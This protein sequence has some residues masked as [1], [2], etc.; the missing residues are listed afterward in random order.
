MITLP[1]NPEITRCLA[2]GQR[3]REWCDRAD[4]CARHLTIH[5]DPMPP[6]GEISPNAV[7]R[8]CSSDLMAGYLPMEGF[9]EA[10]A[11]E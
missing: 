11:D 9:P 8:A 5:C 4:N 6:E 7:Y 1:L 3:E 10:W 2:H